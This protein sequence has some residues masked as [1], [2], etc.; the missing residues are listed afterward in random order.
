MTVVI[1]IGCANYGGGVY[2]IE[3]LI[4][5][6]DPDILY[7]FDPNTTNNRMTIGRTDVRVSRLAAWTYDGRIR[8]T[9]RGTGG[10]VMEDAGE[11]VVSFDLAEFIERNH[12]ER[13][14]LKCDSEGSELTL[15]EHLIE[16]G[17]DKLL[18]LAWIEWH[19]VYDRDGSRRR[20]IEETISCELAEWRF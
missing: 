19:E 11:W 6:F 20:G 17:V 2:S 16:R 1:D 8:Y 14:V 5:E 4:E 12:D 10:T 9:N 3:R 13:T 7:G 15:L 18:S